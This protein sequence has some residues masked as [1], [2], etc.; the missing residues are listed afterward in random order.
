MEIGYYCPECNKVYPGCWELDGV[1]ICST[2]FDEGNIKLI[3]V[4]NLRPYFNRIPFRKNVLEEF[5]KKYGDSHNFTETEKK[6]IIKILNTGLR[7]EKLK[8]IF[9]KVNEE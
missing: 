6:D 5:K 4:D 8:K 2:C 9:N 1:N 3:T 7:K